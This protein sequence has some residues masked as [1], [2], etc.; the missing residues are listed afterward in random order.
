M[1]LETSPECAALVESALR[2]VRDHYDYPS[3]RGVLAS[4]AGWSAD[5][6]REFAA[7]GWLAAPLAE[8]AGGLGLPP[9]VASALMTALG[10][11]AMS[12][13]L[14]GQLAFGA[15][16]V[17]AAPATPARDMLLERWLAGAALVALVSA[18]SESPIGVRT[19]GPGLRLDGHAGAVPDGGIADV[20][21]VEAADPAG[22]RACFL[23]AADA[24]GVT[25]HVHRAAD[26]RSFA[27]VV[28]DGVRPGDDAR[29]ALDGAAM[30]R[31]HTLHALLLAAETLGIMRALVG[32][33]A[34]YLDQREQFGRKLI[35]FQVLQHRLV[36]MQLETVR[37]ESMLAVAEHACDVQGFSAAAPLVSAA[38][39]QSA[40]SGRRV[41]EEAVQL[42]GAIGMTDELVVG[43]YL[44]RIVANGLIA[45][46]AERHLAQA[47]CAR[48]VVPPSE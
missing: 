4:E 21:V 20:F 5:R 41:A 37:S 15:G 47:A 3:L 39:Y 36:D 7:L 1:S 38:Y 2:V 31:A 42:H 33:T 10:A 30:A 34:R 28:F 11:A 40:R 43:H 23:V 44:K 26:G 8:E 24:P 9:S 16:L 18:D 35:E 29:L 48:G 22:D 46:H 17:G 14:P 25:R 12:E 45:G 13:P 32:L 27:D 6:W 19:D